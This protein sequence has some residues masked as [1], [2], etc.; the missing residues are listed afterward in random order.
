[1]LREIAH[2]DLYLKTDKEKEYIDLSNDKEK[3][4][5]EKEADK[6]AELKLIPENVWADVQ[7]NL[8]LN[9]RKI[10]EL[11]KKYKLNPAILLGRA[12]F[13]MN[14]SAVKTIIDKKLK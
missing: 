6:Y 8:P 1:L 10:I 5:A 4:I 11:G 14:Y 7:S 12:C 3:S 2:I 13:E 9:D